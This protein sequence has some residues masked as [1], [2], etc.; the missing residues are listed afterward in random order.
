MKILLRKYNGK[1]FDTRV[2]EMDKTQANELYAIRKGTTFMGV[3]RDYCT[4]DYETDPGVMAAIEA[5]Y[6]TKTRIRVWYEFDGRVADEERDVMGYIG[7]T[8]GTQSPVFMYRKGS[9]S[10]RLINTRR[11][12]RIM[13]CDGCRV[14]YEK[15][16]FQMPDYR[17]AGGNVWRDG[18]I[19]AHFETDAKARRYA[20]AMTGRRGNF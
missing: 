14:L 17:V 15:P 20:D 10:G 4:Y 12:V 3:Q 2:L 13:A 16:N 8:T 1:T 18:K 11:I 6:S 9:Y 19:V 7:R 5:A